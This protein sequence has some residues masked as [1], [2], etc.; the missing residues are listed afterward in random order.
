MAISL[1]YDEDSDVSLS[2]SGGKEG[3]DINT[4]RGTLWIL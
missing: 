4:H 1:L 2:D 3:T